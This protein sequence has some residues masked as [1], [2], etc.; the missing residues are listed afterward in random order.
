MVHIAKSYLQGIIKSLQLKL[1]RKKNSLVMG[2]E[3]E[4]A[5]GKPHPPPKAGQKTRQM[6][7]KQEYVRKRKVY[8]D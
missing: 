5:S 2:E 7:K 6:H 1:T 8:M 4:K 3:H